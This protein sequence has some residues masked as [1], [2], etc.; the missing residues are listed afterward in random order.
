MR[1]IQK[2]KTASTHALLAV[3][4][5]DTYI[6]PSCSLDLAQNGFH[7]FT[8]LKHFLGSTHMGGH[9]EVNK[10]VK[11]WFIG[12]EADF[13]DAGNTETRHMIRQAP[14]SSWGVCRKMI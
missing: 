11:D 13:Y 9:E 7:L 4:S 10:T 8:H 12:L 14:E 1:V 2:V 6:H 3:F 5:W